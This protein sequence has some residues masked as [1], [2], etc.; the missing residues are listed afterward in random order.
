[1]IKSTLLN[2]EA[3]NISSS[4]DSAG[5]DD[6]DDEDEGKTSRAGAGAGVPRRATVGD[7]GCTAMGM[8]ECHRGRVPVR[9]GT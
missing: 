8:D 9:G 3:E 5:T 7:P 1:M 6:M 4:G 2:P